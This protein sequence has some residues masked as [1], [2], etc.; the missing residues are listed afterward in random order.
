MKNAC[1]ISYRHP[2]NDASARLIHAFARALESRISLH[3][4]GAKVYLDDY[5]LRIGD[6]FQEE[7]ATELCNSACMILLFNRSYFDVNHH[8]CAR[9]YQ[10]MLQ[11]EERRLGPSSPDL[12][13]KGLILALAVKNPEH[14][15]DEIKDQ[16][17]YLD[18]SK[19]T[20]AP[21]SF[22]EKAWIK[23]LDEIAEVVAD[24][25]YSLQRL[26]Q[27]L[28]HDCSS[29][30]LPSFADIESWLRKVTAS[31]GPTPMPGH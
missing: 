26:P 15:P 2:G 19:L 21:R 16:R 24:R 8:F 31:Y 6:R 30:R 29:F 4:A 14:M 10:A 11:L 3:I 7:L 1:F 28:N 9:E 22:E 25:Y 17:H 5:K 13:A 12:K 18:I 27:V 20:L 23:R